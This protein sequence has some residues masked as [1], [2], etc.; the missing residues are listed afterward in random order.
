MVIP[1]KEDLLKKGSKGVKFVKC[2]PAVIFLGFFLFLVGIN[3]R[4]APSWGLMDDAQN[5]EMAR[6][7]WQSGSP[8]QNL[9]GLIT[10]SL[11]SW[12]IFW[13]VYYAWVIFV[14]H[15][16]SE[17]PLAIYI[18][19]AILNFISIYLW[20]V[21]FYRLFSAPKENFYS[22]VFL[23]PL[24]FFVFTPFW[25]I[26]LYISVQQKFV[27]FFTA[28]SL[29]FM[30]KAYSLEKNKYLIFSFLALLG[31]IF[32]HPEGIYL[33]AA[34]IGFS[35]SDI[36][37]FRYKKRISVVN[38]SINS[39]F[40]LVYYIFTTGIQ[41]K[42]VYS[43][44]YK[45]NLNTES[46]MLN[47][48]ETS[49]IV[50]TLLILACGMLIYMVIQVLRKKN[51]FQ[52]SA[53]IIPL[54]ILTYLVILLPWGFPNYHIS[55]LAPHLFGLFFL[56]YLWACRWKILSFS[57]NAMIIPALVAMSFFYVGIPRIQK[58]SEIKLVEGFLKEFGLKNPQDFYFIPRPCA[59]AAGAIRYFTGIN[60]AYLGDG[61]LS[62]DLLNDRFQ[63]YLVMRDECSETILE[64][65]KVK[66]E[67]Y[68]NSTWN[69]VNIL[70]EDGHNEVYKGDF[71]KNILQEMI[72]YLRSKT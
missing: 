68:R 14:Y 33:C 43:S 53:I 22:S 5:L 28:L 41:M 19:I 54:G 27:L 69:I 6:T 23:F 47:F 71:P 66:E 13:P 57:V 25:N 1:E 56:I 9:W 17:M 62:Q 42:G 67:I 37:F 48:S 2:W 44:K 63:N 30:E 15:V 29:C 59:E 65:V 18:L 60:I 58:S 38:L 40:F 8:L 51:T 21:V 55:L 11:S 7:V 10:Q 70:G 16:F 3:L 50:K 72:T 35:I 36:L 49:A 20:G 12:G 32:G 61:K 64:N 26:F 39:V 24:L 45:N 4:Y 34:Y 52:P 31:G 46:L